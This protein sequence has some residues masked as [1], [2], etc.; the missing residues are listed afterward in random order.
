MFTGQGMS[1]GLSVPAQLFGVV[2]D[3]LLP[4]GLPSRR[5]VTG[6]ESRLGSIL[7]LPP[8]WLLAV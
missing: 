7:T 2:P 4:Q 5:T 1:L 6:A 8:A 3:G